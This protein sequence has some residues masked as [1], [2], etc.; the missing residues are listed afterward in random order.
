M[1]LPFVSRP[2]PVPGGHSLL[3]AVGAGPLQDGIRRCSCDAPRHAGPAIHA[4]GS[5]AS[6]RVRPSPTCAIARM[7]RAAPIRPPHLEWKIVS[8]QQVGSQPCQRSPGSRVFLQRRW[9]CNIPLS[10]WSRPPLRHASARWRSIAIPST[11]HVRRTI[12]PAVM[13]EK[14]NAKSE[15]PGCVGPAASEYIFNPVLAGQAF[16]VEAVIHEKN[17]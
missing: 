7:R 2:W 10:P 17:M 8:F 14:F 4:A 13:S 16:F 1:S 6:V 5:A 11:T 9:R 12:R 15:P 3:F